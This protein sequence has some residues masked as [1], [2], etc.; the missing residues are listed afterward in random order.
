MRNRFESQMRLG[1]NPIEKIVIRKGRDAQVAVLQA[2]QWV[3]CTPQVNEEVFQLLESKLTDKQKNLGRSGMDLW[4]IL[5]FG[6]MR[7]TRNQSYDDLCYS[8]NNDLLMRE[9]VG[10]GRHEEEPVF[11]LTTIKENV[12]ILT[13]DLLAEIN[14]IIVKHGQALIQKKNE[15]QQLKTD[16]YVFETNVHFPTDLNLA[17][18]AARK[19]IEL[20]TSYAE[21]YS[22]AGWR[23]ACNWKRK[24]KTAYLKITRIQKGGGK[25]KAERLE[26]AVK[27]YLE[28][29]GQ[30]EEKTIHSLK[31]YQAA[32]L[33]P[34]QWVAIEQI[35]QFQQYLTKHI[36]L[37]ER[38]LLKGE[39]IPHEEKIFSLFEPHTE[40]ITKAKSRPNVELGHRLLIT[41]NRQGLVVDYK[42]MESSTDPDEV[43]SLI[44]RLTERFGHDSISSHS[45]DK[46]FYSATNKQEVSKLADTVI[47]PKKGKLNQSE[48]EEQASN[49]F[50]KL[51]NAH[52][53]VESDINSLE[54]HGLDRCPDK[55]LEH[56]K[57]YVGLGILSYNLHQIGNHLLGKVR[58]RKKAA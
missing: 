21:Q 8:S 7:L 26:V 31:L 46:G 2:L 37:I 39:T 22:F 55:G 11:R 48:K 38:R 14:A 43:P 15:K 57:N 25:N 24:V 19:S 3:F 5:V 30:I 36:D 47:M 13:D 52:S 42:V 12:S 20:C 1:V 35:K 53:A 27:H 44:K 49:T 33:D 54:H 6:V 28:Q 45:F 41:S 10:I 9:M 32:T 29:L 23:K 18:D 40:W 34:V 50:R 17:F 58:G 56:Y 16:S 51:R 4:T